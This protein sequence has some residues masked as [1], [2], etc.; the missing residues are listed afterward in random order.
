MVKM[1]LRSRIRRLFTTRKDRPRLDK[2]KAR[3]MDPPPLPDH[4]P[5]TS[6]D[7]DG[8]SA[9]EPA[10]PVLHLSELHR[11]PAT[12][13]RSSAFYLVGHSLPPPPLH[14]A[15]QILT[16][17]PEVKKTLVHPRG[18][19]VRGYSS[20]KSSGRE[21]WDYTPEQNGTLLTLPD[22]DFQET[23]RAYFT[24]GIALLQRVCATFNSAGSSSTAAGTVPEEVINDV[25]FSTM[26][27]LRYSPSLLPTHA[28]ATGGDTADPSGIPRM[29]A[30][31][32]HGVLTLMT[33]TEPSG[34][35]IW[36]RGGRIFS[37]PPLPNAVLII[38]GDLMAHFTSLP[39][40]N[41]LDDGALAVGRDTVLPTV[42]AVVIPQVER[43]SVAVFLRPPREMVVSSGRDGDVTF[44]RW[45]DEKGRIRGRRCWM[46]GQERTVA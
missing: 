2:G 31:T 39:G 8:D 12:L 40:R 9:D 4:S 20:A 16:S 6:D 28:P 46:V 38:A 13:A 29:E 17:S 32:D 30:H 24:A 37:A 1:P 43:Y 41:I 5:D 36:D 45:A 35:Y 3:A 42:H 27:Y 14:Q 44:R 11:A 7:D 15:K 34:L 26:R 18:S 22:E 25:G 19:T 23:T 10:I 21:W 33:A